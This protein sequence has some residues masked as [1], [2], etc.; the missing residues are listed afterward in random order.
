[1]ANLYHF[2]YPLCSRSVATNIKLLQQLRVTHILN[3][4]DG[5]SDMHVKTG[6]EFYLG[7]DII[8]HGIPAS[9]TQ[10]FNLSIYFEESADFITQ[11]LA[12]KGDR[13]KVSVE[14]NQYDYRIN[15]S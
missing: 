12:Y 4:A 2:L 13:G 7:T 14:Q 5:D 11:A 8:Y 3:V 6:A 9:D 10:Y 1:M 15:I